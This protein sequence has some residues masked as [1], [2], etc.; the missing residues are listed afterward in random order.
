V[1]EVLVGLIPLVLALG[2]FTVPIVYLISRSRLV[3][4]SVG[5]VA[6]LIS[7]VLSVL[8]AL[9][10]FSSDAPIVFRAGGWPAPV[11]IV[12]IA[13]KFTATLSLITCFT[14]LLIFIYSVSYI[15]DENYPWYTALLLG[16][17]SGI[18]GVVLT[19]DL[20]NLF[21]MLEVTSVS[22]Y[23]LVMYYRFRA[24]SVMSGLK[25]AFIGAL[26]TTLYLLAM[27]LVYSVFG[28]LNLVDFSLRIREATSPISIQVFSIV[29]ILALW[30]FSIKSGVFP[31]HFW[32]PDAHPAAPTPISALL[33]GLVVNTGVVALYK[34]LYLAT[35]STPDQPLPPLL[36]EV[37][38]IVSLMAIVMGE[39]SGI[40]GA[41]LMYIQRDVKRLI[42]YSTIMNLGYLFM[43]TGCG[44]K[45]GVEATL[46]YVSVHSVAKAT[47]FLSVGVFIKAAKSRDLEKLAGS[48]RAS[49]VAAIALALSTLTLAGAPPLPGFMAKLA[50]YNALFE[51]SAPLAVLMVVTSAIGLISYMKLF[52]TI[53][54]ASPTSTLV[55][56]DVK[57]AKLVL[58]I[59]S[60]AI[61]AA[62]VVF[63]V[64]PQ[65]L[66]TVLSSVSEQALNS[67]VYIQSVISPR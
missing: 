39:L 67:E 60:T 41:L 51:Y 3:V 2:A 29:M 65:L 8:I 57:L 14:G 24:N 45:L 61:L 36:G 4:M 12:Y 34:F 35:W 25:Y 22:A 56:V 49:R 66:F 54:L 55:R 33:S 16:V 63:A 19:G 26:G 42:A 52:Y 44:T 15:T 43:A 13:D 37:R 32:L 47:L 28:T 40:I 64:T 1:V 6:S 30:A 48:W 21:V 58:A 9:S 46:L 20:F 10:A 38:Y 5:V 50:L 11:G 53:L 59:L 23:G 18:L 17:L 27:G 31:N 7:L 62:G